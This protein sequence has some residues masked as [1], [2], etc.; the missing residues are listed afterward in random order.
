MFIQSVLT[1]VYVYIYIYM[2]LFICAGW[3]G[4]AGPAWLASPAG[5]A[6]PAVYI[7]VC[8]HVCMYACMYVYIVFECIMGIVWGVLS[9]CC[10]AL[11]YRHFLLHCQIGLP[12]CLDNQRVM[13]E[14]LQGKQHCE[15]LLHILAYIQKY[16][17]TVDKGKGGKDGDSKGK[18]GS[19]PPGPNKI[20]KAGAW[21]VE[22]IQI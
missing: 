17:H 20:K 7:I 5:P 12:R 11:G 19:S 6:S 9:F 16:I 14:A 18:K 1:Y 2:Y 8:N 15:L 3:P 21:M 4:L 13:A 22:L 10:H